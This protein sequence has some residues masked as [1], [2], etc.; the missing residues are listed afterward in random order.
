MPEQTWELERIGYLEEADIYRITTPA[1]NLVGFLWKGKLYPEEAEEFNPLKASQVFSYM[2]NNPVDMEEAVTLLKAEMQSYRN[3]AKTFYR[4]DTLVE[5]FYKGLL[6]DNR[7]DMITPDNPAYRPFF[8]KVEKEWV[9]FVGIL[10]AAPVLVDKRVHDERGNY[11]IYWGKKIVYLYGLEVMR[12]A[13]RDNIPPRRAL[14]V[15]QNEVA[16]RYGAERVEKD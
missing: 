9:E 16:D 15:M 1:N 10:A 11:V 3:T 2:L 6:A 14:M 4:V 8:E 7:V 5:L 12:R 13:V